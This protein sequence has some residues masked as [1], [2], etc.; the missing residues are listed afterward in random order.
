MEPT[1]VHRRQRPI[2]TP[3][4]SAR[5]MAGGPRGRTATAV[6]RG[7]L[8]RRRGLE[9]DCPACGGGDCAVVG[10]LALA[11]ELPGRSAC[12]S[13]AGRG[14]ARLRARPALLGQRR[15]DGGVLL[16]GG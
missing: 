3:P 15:T 8:P 5:G 4:S 13:R 12:A 11:C 9:W 6:L 10:E 16:R 14:G 2:R 1:L 7:A